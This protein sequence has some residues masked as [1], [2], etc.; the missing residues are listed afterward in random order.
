MQ[1]DCQ[2]C[3][4]CCCFKWSWPVLKRDRSDA[5]NIQPELQHPTLP[6]MRTSNDRCVAMRGTVGVQTSCSIYTDR[7]SA[8][9]KFQ[10]GSALCLEARA[11]YKIKLKENHSD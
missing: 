3:G 7:P 10:P 1:L 9:R 11:K 4:A 5:A 8:C 6:L 2:S